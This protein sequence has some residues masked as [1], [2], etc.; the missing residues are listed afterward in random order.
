MPH[1]QIAAA[2]I[3]LPVIALSDD[4]CI[5]RL[6]LLIEHK[7][8]KNLDEIVALIARLAIPIGVPAY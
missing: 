5:H 8:N 2:P 7:D 1:T 6:A 4:E 3:S